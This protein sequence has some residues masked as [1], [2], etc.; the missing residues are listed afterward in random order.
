MRINKTNFVRVYRIL[1]GLLII[2]ALIIQSVELIR[3][4]SSLINFFSYFTIL[5][6]IVAALVLIYGGFKKNLLDNLRG[7]AS[8]YML[9]TLVGFIVLFGGD[10]GFLLGWVNLVF[11]YLAPAIV[12]FDWFFVTAKEKI[13]FKK[14]L[15]WIL[16]PII[17]FGYSLIRGVVTSW[18]PYPFL[19]PGVVGGYFAVFEYFFAITTFGIL[20]LYFLIKG[21]IYLWK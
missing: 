4:G 10:K 11:H 21:K 12:L 14:A 17:Y 3:V 6:N 19:D 2:L 9:I 5:S 7:A 16:P 8:L 18:Y 1:I 20:G 13:E 15:V